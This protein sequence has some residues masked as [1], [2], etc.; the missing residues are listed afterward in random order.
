MKNSVQHQFNKD[1]VTLNDRASL[2]LKKAGF[3]KITV[4]FFKKCG[5]I[6]FGAV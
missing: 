6:Y 1:L 5:I 4:D 2:L 3:E